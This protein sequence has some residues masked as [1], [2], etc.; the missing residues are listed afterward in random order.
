[1]TTSIIIPTFRRVELLQQCLSSCVEQTYADLEIIVVDDLDGGDE[2]AEVLI[3]RLSDAR[4]RYIRRSDHRAE[5]GAQVSRNVGFQQSTGGTV[6]FLD[7]DDVLFPWCVEERLEVLGADQS[8][9]Y[10]VSSC[11][12]FEAIPSLDDSL[13]SLGR[14]D[15]DHLA[16]FLSST[17]PWQTTG[18]LWRR[19]A[20]DSIGQWDERLSAGH[21]FEFHIRALAKGLRYKTLDR[22]G[23]GWRVPRKDSFSSLEAFKIQ[24][25]RG[26]HL[27]ALSIGLERASEEQAL[28]PQHR[29]LAGQLVLSWSAQCRIY[30]GA[31]STVRRSL[32]TAWRHHCL[33]FPRYVE[34]LILH[35][36][37]FRVGG[38]IPALSIISRR[39]VQF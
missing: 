30:G 39:G 2:S 20:L 27:Q 13:W 14:P 26:D 4:I 18:P 15:A 7:D 23:F 29:L 6:I 34:M 38:R 9:D 21:D 19:A 17:V 28:L 25:Q 22:P 37:W 12:R 3:S 36:I 1:M 16:M 10:V 8:L 5:R 33:S 11:V 31:F 35:V 24:H 32:R